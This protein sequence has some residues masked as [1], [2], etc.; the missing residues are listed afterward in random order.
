MKTFD[1]IIDVNVKGAYFT[2]QKA[3]PVLNEGASVVLV[4]SAA[5]ELGLPGTSVYSASKAALRSFARTLSAELIDRGIRVNTVSPGPVET[6]LFGK[7]E[8]PPEA[9]GEM[10]ETI[11]STVP[12]KR[13]AQAEEI[14]K[15]ILFLAS[16]D[17][18]YFLG[19]ELFVDGGM[20][21][22]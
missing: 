15:T 2:V 1:K 18:S 5:T 20:S 8:L 4:A 9:I 16:P 10:G 13:M 6:P 19:A 7:T 12:I 11:L 14:A 17:S 3:L 21:Q 22:I